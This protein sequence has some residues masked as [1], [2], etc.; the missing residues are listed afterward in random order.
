M[1]EARDFSLASLT[2]EYPGPELYATLTNT[3]ELYCLA[4]KRGL[5]EWLSMASNAP[6]ELERRYADLFELGQTRISLYETEHG[7]M[8]GMSKGNDLAD[9]AGFYRAFGLAVDTERSPEMLDQL[10]VE[11]EFCAHLLFRLSLLRQAHDKEGVEIVEEALRNFLENHVGR[12]VSTVARAPTVMRDSCYGPV[13]AWCSSLVEAQCQR[14][15]VKPP[16]LDFFPDSGER[17]DTSCAEAHAPPQRLA[18]LSR[19][20]PSNT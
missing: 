20:R 10:A 12:Y 15:K 19:S 9:I 14:L 4:E 11:L 17:D 6:E 18:Q 13:L 2:V 5:T 3:A 8:R 16:L 1:K 7:R